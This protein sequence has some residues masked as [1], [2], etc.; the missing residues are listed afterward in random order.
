MAVLT[1][2]ALIPGQSVRYGLE[3]SVYDQFMRWSLRHPSRDIAIIQ[4]DDRSIENIGRWPW[5]RDILAQ[6]VS[7][8]DEGGA[9]V[10]GMSTFLGESQIDGG[11]DALVNV[12][13]QF[14]ATLAANPGSA[15]SALQ[16]LAGSLD[17]TIKRLDYDRTLAEALSRAGTAVLPVSVQLGSTPGRAARP[18]PSYLQRHRVFQQ[19]D[20]TAATAQ[21]IRARKLVPPIAQF[22][23]PAHS[24]GHLSLLLDADGTARYEPLLIRHYDEWYP[25][26]ALSIALSALNLSPSDVQ[27]LDGVGLRIGELEISTT[28]DLRMY[29]YFYPNRADLPAF[30]VDSFYDVFSE[31][32]PA[33]KYKD[34]IV[35]IGAAAS[36]LGDWLK[37][38]VHTSTPPVQVLA[39]TVSAIVEQHYYARPSWVGLAEAASLLLAL[40]YL[41]FVLPR[42][43]ASLGTLIS[44][45]LGV[46]FL[47]TEFVAMNSHAIWL[48][49]ASGCIALGCGHLVI[50]AQRF[51]L[52]ERLR[53]RADTDGANS[54][55]MLGLAFAAQGQLDMAFE[56]FCRCPVDAPLLDAMY[57]LALD[58]ESKRQFNKAAAVYRHMAE[59]QPRYRD[60]ADRM[61]RAQSLEHTVV[62]GGAT[63]AGG[64]MVLSDEQLAQPQLGRYVI[65]REIGRGAMGT[66][67][68]G[69]DP[70]I[71]RVV[72]IKTIPLGQEFEPEELDAIKVRFF[73]EAQSAGRLHHP[74]IVTVYDA[75]EE[76]DLAYIAM[77][78]LSGDHLNRHSTSQSLLDVATVLD[79]M[80]QV[81][82]AL[83][84]AHQA[85]IVHRDVK[86]A[87]IMYDP[88][89]GDVKLTDFGI[90]RINDANRTKTGI[91]LG[92]PSYMPPEQLAGKNVTGHSDIFSLGVTLYQLL[93][94]QLPFRAD[95]MAALMYKIASKPHTPIS[96][97]RPNL[98][99][100][101]DKIVDC[102]LSKLPEQ[103][104]S[105]AAQL[106][107]QLRACRVIVM[108]DH[109]KFGS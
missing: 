23:E 27:R 86:P 20:G 26:L 94:G 18:H 15:A 104:Q 73:R 66:V 51:A 70:K 10:I 85:G 5:S 99:P 11:F 108:Q 59:H 13:E 75:G 89:T 39:H 14:A 79:L 42:L 22:A 61:K 67:Y 65:E 3:S 1:M 25:S 48:Q 29:N 33:E 81:A 82:D 57:A 98:A 32:I 84:Y 60:I 55:R 100:A 54:N 103:R 43:P 56:K 68:Q 36:G 87:N 40:L 92:T 106:A 72:A 17:S 45:A 50:T 109:R 34:K 12:R 30:A 91:V 52:T 102:A 41:M 37:T 8:L 71:N 63:A 88:A 16:A 19:D 38:P 74:N 78:F 2:L 47:G 96:D 28:A 44:V 90:A 6:V 105:T 95:S 7:R 31:T 24:L 53:A 83:H 4:I 80:A 107:E 62:I 64:T 58:Y 35:L 77:E 93:T 21:G 76:H 69:R 97:L 49:L 9:R 101:V 46:A